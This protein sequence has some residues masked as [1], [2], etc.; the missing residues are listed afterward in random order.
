MSEDGR[1]PFPTTAPVA[2]ATTVTSAAVSCSYGNAA[3]L[4]RDDAGRTIDRACVAERQNDEA[5]TN[6]RQ[7]RLEHLL[8]QGGVLHYSPPASR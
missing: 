8:P 1:V 2:S 5:G 4:D 6:E 7:V 3:R